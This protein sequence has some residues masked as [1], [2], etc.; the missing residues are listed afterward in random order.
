[1][2][3]GI[4]AVLLVILMFAVGLTP[5]GYPAETYLWL[6]L[7]ALVPQLLG[8]ST[9]NWALEYLSA[10]YVSIALLGEPIGSAILAYYFLAEVPTPLKIFGAILILTGIFIASMGETK[11]QKEQSSSPA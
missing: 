9:Y 8:H 1:V 11:P 4:A 2:V 10:A 3:Y 5:F 7:L 6:L